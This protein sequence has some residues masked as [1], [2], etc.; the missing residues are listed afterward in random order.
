VLYLLHG[1]GDND[2]HWMDIGRANVIADNLLADRKAEP[3]VIVMP[4]GHVRER[5]PGPPDP[6]ARLEARRA[7]E[8]DLLGNVVPLIESTY[9]V[10]KEPAGRAVAGL[11][12]GSGQALGVGL[13][14]PDRFA[15]VGAFSGAIRPDDAVLAGLRADPARAN[16]RLKLLWLS[17]G[18][19]DTGLKNKRELAAALKEMGV[20]HEYQ[21]TQGG[22]RWSVWRQNL[23]DFLPRL[24]R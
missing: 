23:A 18:Q 24:F 5:P 7:F 12:M 16:G 11:S 6:K 20:R 14:H 2:S 19:D 15:W 4:D 9:R 8:E 1:S 22:H 3:L 17:I 13:G 21:E 10:R